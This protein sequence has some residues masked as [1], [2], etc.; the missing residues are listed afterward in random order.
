MED[1]KPLR[2]GCTTDGLRLCLAKPLE[3]SASP[4]T[5]PLNTTDGFSFGLPDASGWPKDEGSIFNVL[6]KSLYNTA[7]IRYASTLRLASG[8]MT[9]RNI[10]IRRYAGLVG[11]TS[12]SKSRR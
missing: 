10:L 8:P 11:S 7:G 5:D 3:P 6:V 4:L 9:C 1:V 2:H 12:S